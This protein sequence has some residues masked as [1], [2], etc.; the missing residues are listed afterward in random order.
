MLLVFYSKQGQGKGNPHKQT[1]YT[2]RSRKLIVLLDTRISRREKKERI[3]FTSSK[4]LKDAPTANYRTD[5][6]V[7]REIMNYQ[8]N[9]PS[10]LYSFC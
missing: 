10:T 5:Q 4:E 8:L 1:I 3:E 9:G 7:A 6:I 2:K